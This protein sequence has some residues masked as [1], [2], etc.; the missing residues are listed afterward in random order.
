VRREQSR[1]RHS[2]DTRGTS[3]YPLSPSPPLT[4]PHDPHPTPFCS[5]VLNNF[6]PDVYVYT[7]YNKGDAAGLSPGYGVSLVATTTSGCIYGAQRASGTARGL[8]GAGAGVG[9]AGAGS[10]PDLPEDMG[11]D[12]A[13]R[14]LDEIERGGCVDTSAQ[15]LVFSLMLLSPEDVSRVRIGQLGAAGMATL[16]LIRE[17]FGVVFKLQPDVQDPGKAAPPPASKR[18]RRAGE[19][20]EEGEDGARKGADEE[21]SDDGGASR[22]KKGTKE[23]RKRG[24]GIDADALEDTEERAGGGKGEEDEAAAAVQPLTAAIVGGHSGRTVLV[25]CLG[26]GFKNFAKKVT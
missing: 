22:K 8:L 6:L 19:E 5:G 10:K 23:S 18:R 17:F 9:G 20:G 26:I 16:R 12:V 24:R 2:F 3:P 21:D 25:S 7:D 1:A 15:P 11:A 14:L 4:R 13:A